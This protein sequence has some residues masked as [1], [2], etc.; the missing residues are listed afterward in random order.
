MISQR[1]TPKLQTSDWIV[2]LRWNRASG[3]IHLTGSRPS[4]IFLNIRVHIIERENIMD[5]M[6]RVDM[7]GKKLK[8]NCGDKR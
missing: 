6:V 5:N 8:L 3:A 2:Y 1:R 7:F 4:P